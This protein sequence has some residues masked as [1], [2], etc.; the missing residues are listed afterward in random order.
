MREKDLVHDF[1]TEEVNFYA[2]IP[3]N[4]DVTTYSSFH[5]L[6]MGVT[7]ALLFHPLLPNFLFYIQ[8]NIC[9]CVCIYIYVINGY[10]IWHIL[11]ILEF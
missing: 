8:I 6:H 2:I 5:G 3:I 9:V 10:F 1:R 11:Y 4:H 7:P